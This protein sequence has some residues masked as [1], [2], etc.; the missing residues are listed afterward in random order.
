MAEP[1]FMKIVGFEVLTVVVMKSIFFWAITPY[2]PL[3]VNQR[4]GGTFAS[5][6]RVEE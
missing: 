4:F 6:F 1:I 2:S 5:I 3:K